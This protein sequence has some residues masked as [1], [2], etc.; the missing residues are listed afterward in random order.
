MGESIVLF[1][2]QD[3]EV[4]LDVGFDGETVWPTQMSFGG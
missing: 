3:K 2:S 1:E 4:R